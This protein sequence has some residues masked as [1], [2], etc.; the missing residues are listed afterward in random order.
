MEITEEE[1]IRFVQGGW[2]RH[3]RRQCF[4]W[5]T[6]GLSVEELGKS[7][8]DK[9]KKVGTDWGKHGN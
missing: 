6:Q 9:K 7:I 2:A 4:K 3:Q 5:Y 8:A 1:Q